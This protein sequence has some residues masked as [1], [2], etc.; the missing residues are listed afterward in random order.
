MTTTELF[1]T[2]L[3]ELDNDMAAFMRQTG[4]N[5]ASAARALGVHRNTIQNYLYHTTELDQKTRLAMA[6]LL[7]KLRPFGECDPNH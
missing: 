2:N 5:V 7:A 3:D 1:K 6:A 4:L